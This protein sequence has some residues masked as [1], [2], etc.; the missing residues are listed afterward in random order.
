MKSNYS[1]KSFSV[2]AYFVVTERNHFAFN[3]A[4]L[5]FDT[6]PHTKND[7]TFSVPSS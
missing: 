7:S 1:K 2:L 3:G 4:I 6:S 5:D